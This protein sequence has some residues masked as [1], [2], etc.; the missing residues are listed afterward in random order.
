MHELRSALLAGDG[1]AAA[2][3]PLSTKEGCR[4]RQAERRAAERAPSLVHLTIARSERRVTD[5]RRG[6]R[7]REIV[8]RTTIIFRRKRSLVRVVNVSG[9]GVMIESA[10]EPRIGETIRIEFEGFA[11]LDGIVCWVKRGR[12]GLDVGEGAIDLHDA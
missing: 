4:R 7:H 1:G 8:E 5:Q 6:E 12:I 9:S 2:Y 10:I 3:S 11:P